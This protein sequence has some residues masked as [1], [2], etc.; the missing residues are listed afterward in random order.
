MFAFVRVVVAKHLGQLVE[1][2]Q[3]CDVERDFAERRLERSRPGRRQTLHDDPV[4]GTEQH[5]ATD[6]RARAGA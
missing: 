5:D 6:C 1:T 4:R 2:G 3:C